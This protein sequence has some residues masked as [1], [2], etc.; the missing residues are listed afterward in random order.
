MKTAALSEVKN[1]LS[2]CRG[3]RKERFNQ[4]VTVHAPER[5]PPYPPLTKGG[6]TSPRRR[7]LFLPPFVKGG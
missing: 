3:W 2:R 6:K 1:D 4:A 7:L 5:H